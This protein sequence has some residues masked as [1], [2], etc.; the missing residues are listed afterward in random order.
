MFENLSEDNFLLYAMKSYEKPNCIMSEFNED[1][2]HIK[3][4]KKLF[5]QYKKKNILKERLIINHIIL[6]YNVFGVTPATRILFF[7]VEKKY[8]DILKTFLILLN[9]MPKI[10]YGI[11]GE[12]ILSSS[13]PINMEIANILRKI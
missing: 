13:I 1:I 11:N 4:I 2:K 8:Y 10:I 3:Y 6:L 9:F 5:A 12:N 7:K